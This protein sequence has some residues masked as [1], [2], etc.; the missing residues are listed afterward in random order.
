[1]A[2]QEAIKALADPTRRLVFERL[3]R[4]PLPVGR[5]A[6]GLRVT[7]PAVSQHLR[8]LERAGL[9]SAERDG[10]RRLYKIERRGLEELR[11]YLDRFWGDALESFREV[12]ERGLESRSS[13]KPPTPP[14]PRRKRRSR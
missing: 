14:A 10:T 4:G 3:R 13:S 6:R 12:A 11:R 2:Y 8:V 9:V 7:R 5:V 1:M